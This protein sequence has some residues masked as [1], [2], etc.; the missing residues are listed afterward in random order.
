MSLDDENESNLKDFML[1]MKKENKK[2]KE[3]ENESKS[4]G[5]LFWTPSVGFGTHELHCG[6]LIS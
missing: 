5:T 2:K 6:S 4:L 3:K 1:K